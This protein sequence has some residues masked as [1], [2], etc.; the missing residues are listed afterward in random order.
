[1]QTE[2]TKMSNLSCT[3]QSPD[4]SDSRGALVLT[5]E[6]WEAKVM[7]AETVEEWEDVI[8]CKILQQVQ[9]QV[10]QQLLK[11]RHFLVQ[12]I[13]ERIIRPAEMHR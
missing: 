1:M 2:L 5:V 8:A 3:A 12:A 13:G 10:Q 6:E 11:E 9:Q 7:A 4:F